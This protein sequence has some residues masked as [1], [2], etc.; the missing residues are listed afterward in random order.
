MSVL[1]GLQ[2]RL[3]RRPPRL[4]RIYAAFREK[5]VPFMAG[6]VA[7]TAFLSLIP[8]LVLLYFAVAVVN[9]VLSGRAT[10]SDELTDL[11]VNDRGS[12]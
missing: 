8:L 4:A 11:T 2:S 10:P 9:A 5:D 7:F 3:G 6:S 1:S 12:S